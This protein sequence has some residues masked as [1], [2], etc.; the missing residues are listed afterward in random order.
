MTFVAYVI[1]SLVALQR[2]IELRYAERNTAALRAR[3]AIEI[4]TRHYPLIVALHMGWLATIVAMLSHPPVIFWWLLAVFMVLQALRVWVII[5]LGPFWTTRIISLPD[6]PL[7]KRGPYRFVSHP[8]YIVVACEIAVL[9][10]VFDELG[11]AII[12]SLLNAVILA[13]RIRQEETTLNL[14]GRLS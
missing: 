6:A 1:I 4:G 12:F 9:P 8:N 10:L 14:R 11:V 7:V 2:L 3:G 5:T 13:W